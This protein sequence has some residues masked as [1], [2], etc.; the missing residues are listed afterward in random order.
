MKWVNVAVIA[1]FLLVLG[2]TGVSLHKII[3]TT[4]PDFRVL[5]LAVKDLPT[6]RNPYLNPELPTGVGYPPN[7]LSLY[8]PLTLLS[9]LD[10]QAVFTLISLASI[11]GA[12]YLS[13]KIALNNVPWQFLLIGL[14]LS[15]FSF[16]TK[17][18]FLLR[19]RHSW[20]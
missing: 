12:V 5:W 4:A 13:L 8:L 3:S 1:F 17:F 2:L 15:L 20:P 7:T 9:Y 6:E 18:T 14:T 16:P 11:V 19:R 10:A